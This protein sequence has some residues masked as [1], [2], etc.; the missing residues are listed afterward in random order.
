M[1]VNNKAFRRCA[2]IIERKTGDQCQLWS[3][4]NIEHLY[5]VWT[6]NLGRVHHIVIDASFVDQENLHLRGDPAQRP[7]ERIAMSRQPHSTK[8]TRHRSSGNMAY[9]STETTPIIIGS[10]RRRQC[11]R[12]NLNPA[13]NI[14]RH[15]LGRRHIFR[16]QRLADPISEPLCAPCLNTQ[17]QAIS[18]AKDTTRPKEMFSMCEHS[19]SLLPHQR[20][21]IES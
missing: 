12:W 19:H 20:P 11:E 2:H 8:T 17:H 13:N 15:A 6:H 18:N 3:C 16:G 9:P 4:S 7:E 10:D 5:F 14:L 1:S 21:S